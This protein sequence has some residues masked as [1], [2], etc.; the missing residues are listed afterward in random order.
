MKFLTFLSAG[1][2]QVGIMTP[3]GDVFQ[4][5]KVWAGSVKLSH[6]G[7]FIELGEDAIAKVNKIIEKHGD[8]PS[9]ILSL[10]EIKI[11]APIPK[12]AKNI[13]CIGRNYREHIIEGNRARGRNPDDFPKVI[14]VFTK[15]PT[16]VVGTLDKILRHSHIT[17]QLDYEVELGVII[18]KSGIDISPEHAMDHIFGYTIIND[19]TAR[20]LQSAHGQWF[21][22][23][24]LDSTCPMGPYIVHKSLVPDPHILDISLSVNG[25]MRQASNT[26]DLL[27]KLESIV[28]QL[29]A[30]MTLQAGDIIAT[31]TPSGVG[32]GLVPPIFLKSGDVLKAKISG[33][34]ELINTVC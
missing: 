9:M 11:V 4:L 2:Q 1:V 30:G 7:D 3:K 12:P 20:D 15:P 33:L 26:S 24:S 21:K 6:V 18:G 34:G 25:E 22:G 29:S 19:V 28:S 23:K 13:F 10:D 8:D 31:G 27:F 5:S 14:E 32:L 17:E 16:S